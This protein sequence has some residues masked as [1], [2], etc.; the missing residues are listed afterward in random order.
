MKKTV[1]LKKEQNINE[2]IKNENI[3]KRK[4]IIKESGIKYS[5]YGWQ[6]KLSKLIGISRHSVDLFIKR[7]MKEFYNT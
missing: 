7:Y 6:T 2:T 4:N 3:E 5:T 1:S